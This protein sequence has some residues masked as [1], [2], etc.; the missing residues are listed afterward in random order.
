MRFCA[1][2]LGNYIANPLRYRACDPP[3]SE[4]MLRS[5]ASPTGQPSLCPRLLEDRGLK[6]SL[7]VGASAGTPALVR[8][9]L[10]GPGRDEPDLV[11]ASPRPAQRTFVSHGGT[12]GLIVTTPDPQQRKGRRNNS[13][14]TRQ[15]CY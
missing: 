6:I 11:R 9:F 14:P 12:N 3:L 4:G 10:A 5:P 15:K 8:H 2:F 13:A 7:G 1:A